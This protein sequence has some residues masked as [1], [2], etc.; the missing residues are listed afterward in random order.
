M[1]MHME[2]VLVLFIIYLNDDEK[3][4]SI[5]SNSRLDKHSE[6]PH[7]FCCCRFSGVGGGGVVVLL[8][9]FFT[10]ILHYIKVSINISNKTRCVNFVIHKN[11]SMTSRSQSQGQGHKKVKVDVI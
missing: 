1:L 2:F 4:N 10:V 11:Q 6:A 3:Y 8:L 7:C 9:L 5:S